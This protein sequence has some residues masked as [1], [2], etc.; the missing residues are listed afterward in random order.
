MVAQARANRGAR[1]TAAGNWR[2][3]SVVAHQHHGDGMAGNL[4]FNTIDMLMLGVMSNPQQV[5]LYSAAYRV[6][7][8]VLFAYYLLTQCFIPS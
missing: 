3:F 5:G 8:Q 6:M 2:V 7:N 4:A 1:L